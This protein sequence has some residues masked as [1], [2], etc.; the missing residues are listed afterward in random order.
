MAMAATPVNQAAGGPFGGVSADS[1]Y[2]EVFV[3]IALSG[4]YAT[5]GDA[6]DLTAIAKRAPGARG[7]IIMA[8]FEDLAGHQFLYNRTT[9]KVLVYTTA[10]TELA[11]AAYPAGLTGLSVRGVIKTV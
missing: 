2:F 11:A 6:M 4:S 10:G 3:D 8:L 7:N 9:K 5:G 1:G